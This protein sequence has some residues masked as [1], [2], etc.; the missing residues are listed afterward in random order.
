VTDTKQL[1]NVNSSITT[2]AAQSKQCL[3]AKLPRSSAGWRGRRS[4]THTHTT[5]S[6]LVQANN[7]RHVHTF[8]STIN[9]EKS[10]LNSAAANITHTTRYQKSVKQYLY[11]RPP[12]LRLF[13]LNIYLTVT[14]AISYMVKTGRQCRYITFWNKKAVLLQLARKPRD[15]AAV[16]CGLKFADIQY[17]FKSKPSSDSQ[18]S[19]L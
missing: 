8:S 12:H 17:K 19:E 14:T 9:R 18:A 6:W 4:C 5:P 7:C 1:A 13:R 2:D 15:A 10:S 16:R 3:E 11:T